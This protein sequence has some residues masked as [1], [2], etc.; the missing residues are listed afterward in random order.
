MPKR[1]GRRRPI[2][3]RSSPRRRS[4]P[5]LRRGRWGA[6]PSLPAIADAEQT[7]WQG[8]PA[9]SSPISR[10][11]GSTPRLRG[12]KDYLRSARAILRPRKEPRWQRSKLLSPSS[13][14][15]S[16]YPPLWA[17][18]TE[19]REDG[20]RRSRCYP[21]VPP[22]AK[23]TP[24]SQRG[25]PCVPPGSLDGNW[26]SPCTRV[27]P[28]RGKATPPV[29]PMEAQ[30]DPSRHARLDRPADARFREARRHPSRRG[31]FRG[32]SAARVRG[33]DR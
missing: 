23:N 17:E 6:L 5:W 25:A 29:L 28:R 4:S 13:G 16:S 14:F 9:A 3:L 27:G 26:A 19:T 32:R 1:V 31:R 11:S 2:H 10:T 8:T 18:A 15:R 20:C 22:P 30:V 12:T 7:P 33:S 21:S 24:R